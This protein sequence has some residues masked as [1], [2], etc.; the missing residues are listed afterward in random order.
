[1]N[2]GITL[3]FSSFQDGKLLGILKSYTIFCKSKKDLITVASNKANEQIKL[4]FPEHKYLGIEDVFTV[5]GKIAEGEILGRST[6]YDIKSILKTKNLVKKIK[7]FACNKS[8]FISPDYFCISAIYFC[9]GT[10]K[11]NKYTFTVLTIIRGKSMNDA[12]KK[13]ERVAV[14]HSFLNKIS[15]ISIEK[16]DVKKIKFIGIEDIFVVEEDIENGGSFQVFYNDTFCSEEELITILPSFNELSDM[17]ND[18]YLQ[19]G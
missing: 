3:L 7:D 4:H 10:E 16:F 14:E 1:M 18:V 19:L 15:N 17:I 6:F 11:Y 13:F 2:I 8:F 9:N 5:S 12:K